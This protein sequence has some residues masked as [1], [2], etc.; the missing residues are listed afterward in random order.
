MNHL[1]SWGYLLDNVGVIERST[2]S[3]WIYARMV[4][5]RYNKLLS[6]GLWALGVFYG[7]VCLMFFVLAVLLYMQS[8]LPYAFSKETQFQIVYRMSPYQP[9]ALLLLYFSPNANNPLKSCPPLWGG[10]GAAASLVMPPTMKGQAWVGVAACRLILYL[11]FK[12]PPTDCPHLSRLPASN[13][14][15]LP[16]LICLAFLLYVFLNAIFA[17]PYLT[18]KDCFH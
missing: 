15:C 5:W 4:E 12:H 6:A 13:C 17:H 7:N 10:W 3:L 16:F 14:L 9:T 2:C 8:D 1:H 18:V 11:H